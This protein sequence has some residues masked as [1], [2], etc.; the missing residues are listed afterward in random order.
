[1][2][3]L[4][5]ALAGLSL[6]A[7]DR[8]GPGRCD[9]PPQ[10]RLGVGELFR[11][12]ADVHSRV[13]TWRIEYATLAHEHRPG[14]VD[15]HRI[16][17]ARTPDHLLLWSRKGTQEYGWR[18]DPLQE[19]LFVGS[20]QAVV[21]HP[22]SRCFSVVPMKPD[23]PLPGTA[24]SELLFAAL[25]WWPFAHRPGPRFLNGNPVVWK[26][27]VVQS[28]YTVRHE[29]EPCRGRYC[30]V[31]ERT[32]Y[33]R[34]WMDCDRPGVIMKREL[35]EPRAGRVMQ[36][37][38]LDGHREIKDGIWV[39][40][41][42]RNVIF[43]LSGRS[44]PGTALTDATFEVLDVQVNDSLSETVFQF[45]PLAGAIELLGGG[46]YEQRR[47]GGHEYLDALADWLRRHR[48]RMEPL[49]RSQPIPMR[50]AAE[51]M[52]IVL[53][54]AAIALRLRTYWLPPNHDDW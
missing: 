48:Q 22:M 20:V 27:V 15:L 46:R 51:W 11:Q 42:V 16:V 38:E 4:V 33:D 44:G 36:R 53:F 29:Q 23:D 3:G 45:E 8:Q 24:P 2:N 1:M 7:G 52:A 10:A 30:H 18:D 25:G 31:L 14:D 19:R 50:A 54:G 17:A 12:L 34:L 9:E 21:E 13:H 6:W 49:R 35:V 47:P 39:P 43:D 37:I 41:R 40:T 26:D 28:G 5:L 32:G